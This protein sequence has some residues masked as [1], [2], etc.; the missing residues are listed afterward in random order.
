M[1][2]RYDLRKALATNSTSTAFTAKNTSATAPSGDGIFNLLDNS[3]FNVGL[4]VPRWIK[5]IPFGTNGDN[6]TFDMRLYG[7]NKV[8]G[9]DIY[10]PFLLVDISVILCARTATTIAA[11]TFLADTIV[12]NDGPADNGPFRSLIDAQEDI[13]TSLL[14]DLRGAQYIEFDWDL[15]GAQEA[16]SMNCLFSLLDAPF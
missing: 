8:R 5:L 11:D 9:E 10:V 7:W 15:A 1:S 12:V 3:G 13:A 16:A 14:V 2:F 6:D 4:D